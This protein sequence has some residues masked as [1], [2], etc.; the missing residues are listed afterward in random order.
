MSL[1]PIP[2]VT[3]LS[4]RK[5][6]P[7][8]KAMAIVQRVAQK[9]HLSVDVML[10]TKRNIQIAWARAEVAVALQEE[11]H[12][13]TRAIASVLNCSQPAARKLLGSHENA[14]SRARLLLSVDELSK[15][16]LVERDDV[17][18]RN[19]QLEQERK[20]LSG[21]H[22]AD[23]LAQELNLLLR[24]SIMLAMLIEHHPKALRIE[25]AIT[26][27]DDACEALNYGYQ[28]GATESVIVKNLSSLNRTFAERG[29]PK[30]STT[31][32]VVG[33]RTLT[34]ECAAWLDSRL[35]SPIG[36]AA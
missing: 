30:V 31:G 25:T 6:A 18:M 23:V 11:A 1:E 16:S 10:T 12:W 22:M 32:S 2:G 4:A 17:L 29:W 27:Y 24:C 3:C 8:S 15:L 14:K 5:P 33:T 19:R 28:R 26:L 13:S 20:T 21:Q 35:T 7:R 9:H 34:A 36:R